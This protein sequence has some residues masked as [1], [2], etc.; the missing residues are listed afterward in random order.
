MRSRNDGMRRRPAFTLVELLLTLTLSV[1]LMSLIGSAL[2]FYATKL[3]TRNTEVRRVQLAQAILNMINDDL[4]VAIYPPEFDDAALSDLLTSATGGSTEQPG[5]GEDLSAAGLDD[6]SGEEDDVAMSETGSAEMSDISSGSVTTA[7]PGLIGNQTQIQFDLSRLPRLEEYQQQ[8]VGDTIGEVIDV[9]SDIKTVTYFIQPAGGGIVD[10]FDIVSHN[11]ALSTRLPLALWWWFGATVAR[12]F[13]YHVCAG[14][15][16]VNDPIQHGRSVRH[17]SCGAGV[18]ILGRFDLE[19]LLGLRRIW[20]PAISDRSHPDDARACR[21]RRIWRR[22]HANHSVS[23]NHSASDG[24]NRRVQ[25]RFRAVFDGALKYEST[26]RIK[27]EIGGEEERIFPCLDLDRDCHVDDGG[28]FV[29][30]PND[31]VR[32][33]GVYQHGSIASRTA[34]RI[35]RGYDSSYPV[36]NQE[37]FATKW[38]ASLVTRAFFKQRTS[39]PDWMRW[40][41]VTLRSSLLHWMKP[42]RSSGLR[43][44]LQNES[45]RLN[46]NVLPTLESSGEALTAITSLADAAL[47]DSSVDRRNTG[48]SGEV[49]PVGPTGYDRRNRRLDFRFYRRG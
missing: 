41:V 45:A 1:V 42:A 9:P 3:E 43:Y 39:S 29:H 15:R 28:L 16:R 22:C 44:G 38:E 4:R 23:S 7:R 48:K 26:R 5:E 27:I 17:R 40:S 49:A 37:R 46:V 20:E 13:S 21:G 14:T 36:P 35:R 25:R 47:G 6:M 33:S 11:S 19:N 24:T 34:S 30:R 18:S 8:L 12:S 32:R 31:G 10:P 2:S